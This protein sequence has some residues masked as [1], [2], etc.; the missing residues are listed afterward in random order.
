MGK[1]LAHILFF[2]GVLF[3]NFNSNIVYGQD[4]E[5]LF[6]AKC[7]TC[8][9]MGKDGT[10]PNLV[11]VK[12]RWGG[13][14]EFLYEWVLNSPKVI[15]EGKSERAKAVKSYSPTVMPIQVVTKDEAKAIIDY[16]DSWVAPVAPPE[17][18]AGDEK[19]VYVPN[20]EKNLTLFYVLIAIIGFL[21][22]AILIVSKST[23]VVVKSDLFKKRIAE[24]HEK[25]KSKSGLNAILIILFSGFTTQASALTTEAPAMAT[26]ESLWL[27][28]E[29]SELYVLLIIALLLLGFLLHMV[30]MFY[31]F[32]YLMKPEEQKQKEQRQLV[33][34]RKKRRRSFARSLTGATP[35]EEEASIDLGHDYDGIRELD[36]PMP[37]WWVAGFFISIVFAVVYM[38]H[39]H[40]L[41]TGD[42]QEVEYAKVMKRE[43]AKVQEYLKAQSMDID[44]TNATLMIDRA[45]LRNGKALFINNCAVCHTENGGGAVGPNLTD[46]YWIYG[47]GIKDVF[48]VIKKGA[49]NG[50]PE[51]QSKFN[52]IEIQQAASYVLNLAEVTQEQ[53]GKEPEGD[54]LTNDDLESS[55]EEK[56][57]TLQREELK[58]STLLDKSLE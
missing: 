52:P 37:P 23:S 56:L 43:N 41:G 17:V 21:L 39:Y 33:Q 9:I 35:V 30:R 47:N 8:H 38:F 28:V 32:I 6:K 44:E 31:K 45:D 49:P 5:A 46:D 57:D 42:L 50:M 10:G 27:Y 53:G 25:G 13:E 19:I 3:Y 36:N 40:V 26:K 11:G 51:H 24:L 16:A 22:L 20:Y 58:D 4:G 29:N 55:T 18:V 14:E 34:S 48:K 12:S 54:F 1:K 2:L 7:N 15:A